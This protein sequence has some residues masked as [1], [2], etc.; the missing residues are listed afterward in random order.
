V[1]ELDK[2]ATFQGINADGLA[3]FSTKPLTKKVVRTS[4]L[5]PEKIKAARANRDFVKSLLG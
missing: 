5:C 2:D 4:S 3:V 1:F